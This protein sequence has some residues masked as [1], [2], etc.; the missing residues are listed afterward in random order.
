[1]IDSTEE[2]ETDLEETKGREIPVLPQAPEEGKTIGEMEIYSKG[3][4]GEKSYKEEIL[5]DVSAIGEREMDL[6]ET[7]KTD[8]S[9]V[10]TVSGEMIATEETKADLKETGREVS[11]SWDRVSGD[12]DISEGMVADLERP[13]NVDICLRENEAEE[14]GTSRQT[15]TNT[16]QS[17]SGNCNPSPAQDMKVSVFLFFKVFGIL[18]FQRKITK[19]IP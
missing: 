12:T 7:G 10:E 11:L 2:S 17:G 8:I 18:F 14:S 9:L 6:K 13:G 5:V 16:M 1:M 19:T 3:I 4:I 15:E